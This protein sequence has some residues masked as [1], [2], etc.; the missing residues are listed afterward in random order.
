MTMIE[1]DRARTQDIACR[2]TPLTSWLR[3]L[4]A[5]TMPH[6]E[7]SW[8]TLNERLLRD[9]GKSTADAELA[10]LQDRFGVTDITYSSRLPFD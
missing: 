3:R 5:A 9:I 7:V 1:I 8:Q 6:H 4:I 10:K 2:R